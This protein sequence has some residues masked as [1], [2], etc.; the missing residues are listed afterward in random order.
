MNFSLKPHPLIAQWVPG[1][2]FLTLLWGSLHGWNF[3]ALVPTGAQ[4][5]LYT[6]ILSVAPFVIG[7]VFDTIRNT[8]IE[9][10]FDKCPKRK[11]WWEE[12]IT[13]KEDELTRVEENYFTYYVLDWNLAFSLIAFRLLS[14]LL[15]W[16]NG[17]PTNMW[18]GIG[19]T[20]AIVFV[21]RLF[22]KDA[23]SLRVE[24]K[25]IVDRWKIEREGG[26]RNKEEKNDA[27]N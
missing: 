22:I 12:F 21:S 10:A 20:L 18:D 6:L 1:F 23:I 2:T 25:V 4:A 16:L 27:P 17:A 26:H 11:I 8:Y 24:L 5:V 7:Q 13:A 19:L 3:S 14:F 9:S 15:F